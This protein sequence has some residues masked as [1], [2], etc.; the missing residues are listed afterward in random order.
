MYSKIEILGL[1]GFSDKQT[2]KFGQPTG[3]IG[4]GLTVIVGPKTLVSP[5]S[6]KRFAPLL[7]IARPVLLRVEEIK[8]LEIELKSA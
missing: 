8:R 5:Q 1:R 3:Q 7:K 6:M 4:S 2:L